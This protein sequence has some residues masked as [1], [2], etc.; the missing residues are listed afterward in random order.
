M[1]AFLRVS[2]TTPNSAQDVIRGICVT[3][4]HKIDTNFPKRVSGKTRNLGDFRICAEQP[5][6]PSNLFVVLTYRGP[7]AP[8]GEPVIRY[9]IAFEI[10]WS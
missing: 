1:D 6:G 10:R 7:K 2:W 4:G 8:L 9:V 3:E 5:F